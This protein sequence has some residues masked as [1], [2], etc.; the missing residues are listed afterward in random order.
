M[1]DPLDE[2][3]QAT[4]ID[5][6]R[7][8][9]HRGTLDPCDGIAH[10]HNP[11][12]GDEIAVTLRYDEAGRVA[13]VAFDGKGCAISQASADLMSSAA[14]GHTPEEIH[15]MAERFFAMVKAR[16]DDLG[17]LDALGG[18]AALAGVRKLPMR[19]K[20]ATLAWHALLQ[21]L[22]PAVRDSAHPER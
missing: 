14:V 10:G 15:A 13:A 7:R 21:A 3:Y 5:R 4:I 19:V 6:S 18:L 8:P 20:C 1:T 2:I 9:R 17:D 16:G 11:L 22:C 12:C